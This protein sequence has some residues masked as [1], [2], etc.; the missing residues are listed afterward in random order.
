MLFFWPAGFCASAFEWQ[1]ARVIYH[2]LLA[3]GTRNERSYS[4]TL[5]ACV[6]AC[7]GSGTNTPPS[8]RRVCAQGRAIAGHKSLSIHSRVAVHMFYV[9]DRE[10]ERK[11]VQQQPDCATPPDMII[12][13]YTCVH[14]FADD[15]H[16]CK[17]NA[18][19]LN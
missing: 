17:T 3:H 19:Q 1:T 14:V 13:T 8:P 15:T 5:L 4:T 2:A 6:R 10:R 7:V 11:R 9:R 16:A 18:K 12:R